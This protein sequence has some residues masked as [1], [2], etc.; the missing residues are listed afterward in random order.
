MAITDFFKDSAQAVKDGYEAMRMGM[1]AKQ[2]ADEMAANPT[3]IFTDKELRGN[4]TDV[5]EY[6]I[7]NPNGIVANTASEMGIDMAANQ[8]KQMTGG[9]L[10][11]VIDEVAEK[12][13]QASQFIRDQLEK[14]G[15]S[16]EIAQMGRKSVEM[17]D[18]VADLG[19]TG[20]ALADREFNPTA[21]AN[22]AERSSERTF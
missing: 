15:L 19:N 12:A 2:V 8:A 4:A 22:V 18:A 14:S 6:A 17:F 1:K 13:T 7:Q 20:Q 11:G 10:D 3:A 9:A 5:A 16:D 21:T